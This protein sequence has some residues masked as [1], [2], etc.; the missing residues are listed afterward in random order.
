MKSLFRRLGLIL[1]SKCHNCS[2]EYHHPHSLPVIS[3]EASHIWIYKD[4]D[5]KW[6]PFT[7]KDQNA[8]DKAV[9]HGTD[10]MI[11][12]IG[13][14]CDAYIKERYM[15]NVYELIP[16]E[17]RFQK[18]IYFVDDMPLTEHECQAI[19]DWYKSD[20]SQTTPL[21]IG[22][23]T[24]YINSDG[25]V[26]QAGHGLLSVSRP[27]IAAKDSGLSAP[28]TG[29]DHAEVPCTHLLLAVHGIGE[30]LWSRKTFSLKPF[31]QNCSDMRSI[32]CSMSE[33]TRTEIISINWFHILANSAYM[34]RIADITLP[35]IPIFR[36]I[37]N[38]AVADAIF[39]LNKDH[40]DAI[41]SHIADRIVHTVTLFKQR[42]PTWN[43]KLSLVGH[44]LGSVISFDV[45]EH[46][47]LPSEI[48]VSNLFLLG[49]P[50]S[51]FL[52]ARGQSEVLP[53]NQCGR[54]FN[55]MQPNDPV[56]Y[57][58]EPFVVPVLKLVDPALIP[59]HKTGGL[60]TTTQVRK[61]ASSI[62]GLFSSEKVG[63]YY[64]RISDVVKDFT[65]SPTS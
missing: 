30:S 65:R 14:R 23:R 58:I 8:I 38:E 33:S 32:L 16:K 2:V 4:L 40:R 37:A 48:Q 64:E 28:P 41:V 11:R 49:S 43:N 7:D 47:K 9:E 13:G 6:Q 34:K 51:L 36:Q 53:F 27:L 17:T 22:D 56:A 46:Q 55:I 44:S 26:W 25:S 61:T 31:D 21:L 15:K 39:Y 18:A 5:D 24:F 29:T 35:S 12:L 1:V 59:N 50:L 62:L 42:N 45:L 20:S 57:R 54:I 19:S 60:A 3:M 63:S 52:T 10:N